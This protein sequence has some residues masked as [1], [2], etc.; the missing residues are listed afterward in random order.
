MKK[1]LYIFLFFA[2]LIL[3][4][5][6]KITLHDSL[7]PLYPDTQIKT[8]RDS[9]HLHA[10]RN[11]FIST[12]LFFQ[13]LTKY[14]HLNFHVKS[15]I[16]VLSN[17]KVFELIDVPLEINTGI[18]SRTEKWDN[19]K[20]PHVIRRAPFRIYEVLKPIG[21]PVIT[22]KKSLAIRFMWNI[23]TEIKPGDYELNINIKEITF[24][25]DVKVK[26]TVHDTVLP[27]PGQ[28]TYGYTNWFSPDKIAEYH[29]E[30]IWD[31]V[32]W[33]LL[34]EYASLMQ[35]GR[36]NM[37]W[38]RWNDFFSEKDG[39]PALDKERLERYIHLFTSAGIHYIEFSPIA[40][41]TGG[42]W[43]SKTLSLFYKNTLASSEQG[44]AFAR[45][46]I[47]QVK[48]VLTENNWLDRCRFHIADEP[49]DVLVD[50]YKKTASLLKEIVP[51][52]KII[53]ATMTRKLA[54][55]VNIWCPQLQNFQQHRNFFEERR[56][57]GDEIWIYSC[58]IPGGKWLNRLIDQERLRPVYIGWS[59]AK[60]DLGGYLHW[61]LN[62]WGTDPFKQSV[63]DHFHAQGTNN[64]L[65]AGDTHVFYP[66]E[67]E[68]WSSTRF[69][70]HRVG[71]E[72]AELFK[73]LKK[74]DPVKA[75]AIMGKAFRAYNDYETSVANYRQ[76]RKEL[77]EAV[78]KLQAP[79]AKAVE[80]SKPEAEAK[81]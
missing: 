11:S 75:D 16:P 13:N 60:Y 8:E 14:T 1:S 49:T 20:N 36:Q 32:F 26:I 23:P 80:T 65:P 19:K 21:Y 18:E 47:S 38:V 56:K 22:T 78:D 44:Q 31:S 52:S 25:R 51:T 3:A 42:N 27:E 4:A 67:H 35:H 33:D 37:F 76:V 30:K 45:S 81:N 43:S 59:L 46:I 54:G 40:H 17:P 2:G 74:Q 70:A 58:L 7:E 73:L 79:Q 28:T 5:D 10:P 50:D 62:H 29:N 69:E 77:L 57:A 41:R 6:M 68:P 63:I 66:G 9:I 39:K 71:M 34:K 24:S 15:N 48:E 12:D 61:G 72:D 64:Q 55:A 53:E